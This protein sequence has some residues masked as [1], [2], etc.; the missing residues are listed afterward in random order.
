M[1]Y[2]MS[3]MLSSKF[4]SHSI[5]IEDLKINPVNP[6]NSISTKDGGEMVKLIT[7]YVLQYAQDVKF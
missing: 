2:S 3:I 5:E 1:S 4:H 7:R 6:F